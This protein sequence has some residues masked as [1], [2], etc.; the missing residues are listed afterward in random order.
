MLEKI[1]KYL[2]AQ[3]DR[4]IAWIGALGFILEILLHSQPSGIMLAL[5]AALIAVP[6]THFSEIFTGWT[7]KLRDH[8]SK[9]Q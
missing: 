2:L 6:D 1:K 4:T 5:F 9:S 8:D 3:A 7:K